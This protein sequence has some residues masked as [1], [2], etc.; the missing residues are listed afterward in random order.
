M[1]RD[2]TV[3]DIPTLLPMMKEFAMSVGEF[4]GNH[5]CSRST[6]HLLRHCIDGGILILYCSPEPV[7]IIAGV[8]SKSI[9]NPRITQ[10]DEIAYYVKEE[11]RGSSAG[12]RLLREWRRKIEEL[13]PDMSTLKL[14]HNS[15]DISK[16]YNKLGYESL[17][18]TFIRR[19]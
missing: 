7:G 11:F 18:T 4:Y 16:H 6:A 10:I 19:A 14:M 8:S 17:E 13:S 1:I 9:W 3:D 12:A 2:A 15:P 5:I